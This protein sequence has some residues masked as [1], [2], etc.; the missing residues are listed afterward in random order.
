MHRGNIIK[1]WLFSGCLIGI[2]LFITAC[3][4][5]SGS[6]IPTTGA[7][8]PTARGQTLQ[9]A[10]VNLATRQF[11]PFHDMVERMART[12]VAMVGEEHY[13]PA[14]QAVVLYLLEQLA[15]RRPGQLAL[16]MEF[17][18]RDM[19]PDVDAYLAGTIDEA[20]FLRRIRASE[21]F[22][23]LYF[24]LLDYARQQRL[25]VLAINTP[26]RIA[27]QVAR[28]GLQATLDSLRVEERAYVAATFSAISS[29]YR[30]YF[31]DAVT[32]A[33]P[34]ANAQEAERFVEAS[35]MKDDTMAEGLAAFLEKR[36]DYTVLTLTGRFHTDY[37]KA[38]PRLLQQ[39]RPGVTMVRFTT[40]TVESNTQVSLQSLAEEALADYL[41]FAPPSGDKLDAG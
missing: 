21:Q 38:I 37:G 4:T 5:F 41:W 27:T 30:T 8:P 23:S 17:L 33:H 32:Q 22:I 39:R 29:D 11:V 13:Q 1:A 10:V 16:A 14:I 40:I 34:P 15:T 19:Q 7:M 35:F 24:P 6:A 2:S 31:L 18:E 20:T 12:Q 26:R 3:A 9:R 28:E 25:P 36:P